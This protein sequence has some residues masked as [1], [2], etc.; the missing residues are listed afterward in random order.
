[1]IKTRCAE[2]PSKMQIPTVTCTNAGVPG[3]KAI[4]EVRLSFFGSWYTLGKRID[5]ILTLKICTLSRMNT[6]LKY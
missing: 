1:M 3:F 4:S 2:L 5:G 6:L